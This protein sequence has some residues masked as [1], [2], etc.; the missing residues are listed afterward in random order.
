MS[1]IALTRAV[2]PSIVN[3]ELT[4]LDRAPIV[5][6]VAVDQHRQYEERLTEM[7]CE[8]VRLASSDDLPDSVFIEDT[9]IVLDEIAIMT[10][11]GAASRRGE[12]SAVSRALERYR[13]IATITAPAT[14]DGGDVL[15][16]GRTL[17]VGLSSRTNEEGAAQ[18]ERL[19]HSCGRVVR[20]IQVS[21]CLHLKTAVTELADNTVLLNPRWTDAN[22]FAGLTV[23]EVD[24]AEPFGANVVRIGSSAMY[25]LSY[26]RTLDRLLARGIPVVTVHSSELAKAEGALTCCSLLFSA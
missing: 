25:S 2:S 7:G 15:Q 1:M 13:P 12:T 11:P 8:V 23:V 6:E 10:R 9:A 22:A 16:V 21:Q 4:H 19:A 20:R 14:I 26:P 17:F 18:L 24:P 3:C 5:L